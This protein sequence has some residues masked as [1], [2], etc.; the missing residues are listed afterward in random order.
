MATRQPAIS[1]VG[2]KRVRLVIWT[3]LQ[4]LDDGAPVDA[5]AWP[6]KSIAVPT[7]AVFGTGGT[8]IIEGSLDGGATWLPLNDPSST[9]L[10]FTTAKIRAVMENTLLIRPRVTAGD[11]TTNITVQMVARGSTGAQA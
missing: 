5:M 7:T 1:F 9:A 4:N 2:D 10:S 3:G 8:V 6:D 11:G